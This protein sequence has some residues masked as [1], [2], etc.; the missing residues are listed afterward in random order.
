MKEVN[1]REAALRRKRINLYK[2]IMVY[3]FL[4][5]TI[6]P[7]V[8]SILLIHR[9]NQ[10]ED[11]LGIMLSEEGADLGTTISS[12]QALASNPNVDLSH[13]GETEEEKQEVVTSQTENKRVYLTFDDG[14]SA[15]TAQIL[16][17]LK[18]NDVKAT[19]FVIARE[20]TYY[21]EYLKRIVDE[22]HTIGIHSYTHDYKK[23][24]SS[25]ETFRQ[26]V[27]SMSDYIYE[28][29][30]KRTNIYRFPGGSSNTV[31]D[32]DMHEC[33]AYLNEI[34]MKYYD[35]NA[36]NGDAVSNEL[37]EEQL[38]DN[39]MKDVRKNDTSIVLMHDMQSRHTT[40][41]SLQTLITILKS[42]GYELLPIDE[43]TP[44]I[45]HKTWED[46]YEGED[47]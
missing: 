26:D 42:E 10:L 25:L 31:A 21:D 24:Y 17:I 28:K 20:D 37:T 6:V 32:I 1:A 3:L 38:I 13:L 27:N 22:G 14:P 4:F 15:Y 8:T 23:I 35:W 11:R 2:R 16:D 9:V 29:T 36:L 46:V 39:I 18:M 45:Q 44:M 12:A 19:F 47:N 41:D 5:A 40:V 30:G 7:S 33:I 43:H 34:G